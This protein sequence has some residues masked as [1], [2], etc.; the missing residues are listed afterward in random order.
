MPLENVSSKVNWPVD[1]VVE[2]LIDTAS[3]EKD[4]PKSLGVGVYN[5]GIDNSEPFRFKKSIRKVAIIGAGPAGV[6]NEYSPEQDI[7]FLILKIRSYRQPR[8]CLMKV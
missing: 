8:Y 4:D 2:P 3:V 5:I 1:K 7:D 6:S